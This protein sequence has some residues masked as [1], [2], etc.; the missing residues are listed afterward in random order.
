MFNE[1]RSV[2]N[3]S[4]AALSTSASRILT[5]DNNR[6]HAIIQNL[7]GAIVIWVGNAN[8]S[9]SNGGIRLGP[10][11]TMEFIG[12]G[13]L[14]A[15]AASGT[16]SV[17]ITTETHV[18]NS[19]KSLVFGTVTAADVA[20]KLQ[21]VNKRRA[22]TI[23]QNLSASTI[24][25]GNLNVAGGT[26]I[27]LAQNQKTAFVSTDAIY[28]SG[29]GTNEVQTLTV[30]ATGGTYT[31]SFGGQTTSALAFNASASTI[32]TALRGLSSIGGTNVAVTGS[33]PYTITFSGSLANTDVALITAD[34]TSLTGNT[35]TASLVETTKGSSGTYTVA[36]F[37]ELA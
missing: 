16:P 26:G 8:V 10:G 20:T 4:T 3:S 30:D 11:E 19:V 12:R 32:Q 7:D 9:T 18:A 5:P 35:H 13:S 37:A 33:G 28:A 15:V 29:P 23:V 27:A 1:N 34:S 21:S 14:Y 36:V 6:G 17:G 2:K 25:V 31:L 24:S 22:R